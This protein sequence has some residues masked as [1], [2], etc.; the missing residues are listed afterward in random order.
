MGMKERRNKVDSNK[1]KAFKY[2]PGRVGK[3][4][5]AGVRWIGGLIAFKLSS[6]FGH[7][8]GNEKSVSQAA[9]SENYPIIYRNR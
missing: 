1:C 2:P 5:L 3:E 7:F 6:L 4:S 8:F 9:L